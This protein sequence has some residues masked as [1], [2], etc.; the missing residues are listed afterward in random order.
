MTEWG[1]KVGPWRDYY[2]C[3]KMLGRDRRC[4]REGAKEPGAAVAEKG[5]EP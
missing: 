2:P 5:G 3:M 4:V 1:E